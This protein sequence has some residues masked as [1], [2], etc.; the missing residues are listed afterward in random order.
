MPSLQAIREERT[1]GW[2]QETLLKLPESSLSQFLGI[3]DDEWEEMGVELNA[4]TGSSDEMIYCYW[5][6]VPDTTSEDILE[7]TRWCVG[8]TIDD[9]PVWLVE[10][11]R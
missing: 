7:K 5:F 3:T 4:N 9:I 10:E 8:Q 11:D 1:T 6:V 2:F